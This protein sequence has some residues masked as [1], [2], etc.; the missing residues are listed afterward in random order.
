MPP[1]NTI[2]PFK[3]TVCGIDELAGHRDG[4]VSHVLSILDPEWPV[5]EAFGAFGEHA[6]LELRF[7]DIIDEPNADMIA[8]RREHVAQLL[9]F[10]HGLSQEPQ[11][12][13]HL[14]VHCHAGVSRSTASMALILAQ[15]LPDVAANRVLEEV[16]RIRPQAWPNLRIIELGDA[17]LNRRG[18]LVA[19]AAGI[20]RTQL[21]RR[22]Y[23][24][25]QMRSGGRGREIEAAAS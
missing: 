17:Q 23:L 20:Y 5:P 22:Q 19:A 7:H 8:P 12:D 21:E 13:A 15:A 18:E 6:K 11:A 1:V 16:L 24:V 2:A 9:S 10:G 3:I 25:E 4:K 14:L